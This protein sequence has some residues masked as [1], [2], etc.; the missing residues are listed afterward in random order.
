MAD[1]GGLRVDHVMGLSRLFWIPEGA[2]PAHGTYVRFA[3]RELL[4]V[5]AME[6]ARAGAVIV[7]EDLGT[8]EPAFRQELQ[9]TRVLSTRLVWFEDVP[10]ERYPAD[11][12]AMVTTHDLPTIAG[13][14]TGADEAELQALGRPSPP[15][16]T[17]RLRARL[18]RLVDLPAD[19][20]PRDVTAAVHERLG[21][22]P[23][24]LVLATLEDVCGVETRPNVPGTTDERPNWSRSL[25]LTIDELD[26]DR[27][28]RSAVAGLA[29][30]RSSD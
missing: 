12:L 11:A 16:A 22:S 9:D 10:P 2:V 25:P 1:G 28:V 8:V 15:D 4:D 23:A 29:T 20:P 7:G 18:D 26:G 27:G 13:V 6:S 19:A 3:G 21:R 24:H 17:A 30:A 14:W 5:L